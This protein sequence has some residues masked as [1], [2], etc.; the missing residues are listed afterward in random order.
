MKKYLNTIYYLF[1]INVFSICFIFNIIHVIDPY[2]WHQI[3]VQGNLLMLFDL[4]V[5]IVLLCGSVGVI[6]LAFIGVLI[7]YMLVFEKLDKMEF[8]KSV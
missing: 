2:L 3:F 6:V 8:N 7:K 1:L 5:Y 4:P